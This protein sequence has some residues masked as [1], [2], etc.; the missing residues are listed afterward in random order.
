MPYPPL[1]LAAYG[2]YKSWPW[3]HENKKAVPAPY[4]LQYS[5]EQQDLQQVKA[6]PS[7]G[8]C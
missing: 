1:S 6:G 8:H 4:Q 3:G 5:G 7:S 2:Y